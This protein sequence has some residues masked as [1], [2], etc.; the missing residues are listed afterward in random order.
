MGEIAETEKWN[1][2]VIVPPDD[3]V[4]VIDEN[5]NIGLAQPCYYPFEVVKLINDDKKMWGWRGTPIFYPDG[6]SRWDGSW[7]IYLNFSTLN[8]IGVI[9]GWRIYRNPN[10]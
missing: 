7:A 8:K 2:L 5:G 9:T 6:K 4:E 1:D 3:I 10:Q